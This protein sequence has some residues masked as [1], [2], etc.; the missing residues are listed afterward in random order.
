MSL[1]AIISRIL[2]QANAC[3]GW[4]LGEKR[5]LW[6]AEL[7]CLI[8]NSRQ[9]LKISWMKPWHAQRECVCGGNGMEEVERERPS[10]G[11]S[12]PALDNHARYEERYCWD[13][14]VN[15]NLNFDFMWFS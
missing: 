7:L 3:H 1:R 11:S 9:R 5:G 13:T 14:S 6:E 12:C 10:A 15:T 2:T 4:G 8:R